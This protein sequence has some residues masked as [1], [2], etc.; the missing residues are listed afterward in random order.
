MNIA[1]VRGAYL[2]RFET[3]NYLMA[4]DNVYLTAFSSLRPIHQDFPFPHVGLPSPADFRFPP[5]IANRTFGDTQLLWGLERYADRFDLFHTADPHYYYSY[6]LARLRARGAIKK[7]L[8]T[9]WET[10]PHNNESAWAK[11]KIK[12][13]TQRNTDAFLCHCRRAA[14]CLIAEGVSTARI[15]VIPLGVDLA[16]FAPTTKL[17]QDGTLRI[18]FVGRFVAEK[19]IADILAAFRIAAIPNCTL[20]LIGSGPMQKYISDYIRSYR[21]ER[22]ISVRSVPYDQIH[23]EYRSADIAVAPSRTTKTWEEQYG[24]AL[25]EAMASGLAIVAYRTGAIPEVIGDAGILVPEGDVHRLAGAF[26][27]LARNRPLRT[28]LGT[29]S[30]RRASSRYDARRT[31]RRIARLYHTI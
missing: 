31:A 10:I 3:Q 13:F 15:S 29:M 4:D 5:F 21:L 16:R 1:F 7:L 6:Q 20:M 12:M 27:R 24:M 17:R 14:D 18:V 30:R 19:G 9:S 28:K 11:K 25:V 22:V 26:L 23:E 8:V 2:N